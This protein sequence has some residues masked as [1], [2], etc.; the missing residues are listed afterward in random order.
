MLGIEDLSAHRQLLLYADPLDASLH[1]KLG[2]KLYAAGQ[3]Q[4]S[5]R[6]YRVLLALNAHDQAA[7]NF[8]IARALNSMGDRATSRR[9]LLQALETAPH[10]RPAQDLLLEMTGTR[11]P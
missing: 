4:Q 3:P 2:E 8:G 10:Y 7:A 6:E 1:E 5:L 11:T 9:H